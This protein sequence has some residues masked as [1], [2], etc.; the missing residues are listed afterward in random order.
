MKKIIAIILA[1][2]LVAYLV[3]DITCSGNTELISQIEQT[4][5]DMKARGLTLTSDR[6]QVDANGEPV[7]DADG[8][9][10]TVKAGA[11]NSF[12]GNA[13]VFISN[14]LRLLLKYSRFY[15]EGLTNTILLSILALLIGTVLGALMALMR[16]SSVG[17]LRGFA[18]TYI[19]IFRGTPL[20]VQLLFIY[21]GTSL[22]SLFP[23]ISFISD[24]PR[25]M[26]CVVVM[27]LNSCAYVAEVIRSGI[28]AVDVGQMEAARSLGFSKWQSMYKVILP[29]AIKNILPALGNEFI[30]VIKESSIVIYVGVADLMYRAKGVTSK[31]YIVLESYLIAAVIY[32]IL[33]FCLS[34]LVDAVERRMKRGR[35]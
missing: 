24:F 33:T 23:N 27:S 30:T 15:T 12:R 5:S 34:T 28:Q 18:T 26:T 8:Q 22:T 13:L 4:C 16:I 9:P 3:F 29:Q 19:E 11:W 25:M 14:T 6:T 1:V 2:L 7:L 21:Y 31:T 10:V 20:M 32:F 35:N 17:V